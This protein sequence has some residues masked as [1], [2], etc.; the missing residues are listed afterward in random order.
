MV[1]PPGVS[2]AAV[3]TGK[4]GITVLC[5]V[6]AVRLPISIYRTNKR[7]PTKGVLLFVG[8]VEGSRTPVR[9][10]LDTAFSECS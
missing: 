2:N 8:G 4:T 9:K 1:L 6:I 7:T 3:C 10:P 5:T